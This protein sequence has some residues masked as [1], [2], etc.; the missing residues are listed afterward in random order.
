MKAL[1]AIVKE[2]NLLR[3]MFRNKPQIS[4]RTMTVGDSIDIIRY[5]ESELSPE[6]LSMDGERNYRRTMARK[7]LLENAISDLQLKGFNV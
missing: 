2:I 7:S 6:N 1:S 5:I 3:K 4:M